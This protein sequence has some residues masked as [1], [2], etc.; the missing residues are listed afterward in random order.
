MTKLLIRLFIKNNTDTQ[1]PQIR[2]RYGMLAGVVGIILNLLLFAGKLIAGLV[3]GAISITADAFNNLSDAGSSIITLVGFK[4]ANAPADREHPFGHGRVEYLAGL[5]V[6]LLILLMGVE[7]A[8]SS[9]DKILRPEEISFSALTLV[10]LIVSVLVKLWM[11]VFN[12]RLGRDINSAPM[13]AAAMDS[14]SDAVATVAVIA[15]I[16]IFALFGVNIDGFIGMLVAIFICFTGLKTAKESFSPIVG[17]RPD[18]EFVQRIA[19]YVESY[20]GIIGIHDLIVHNYGVGV[21]II[22]LHAEV[23]CTME[24]MQAHELIDRLE[25]ELR[26]R[27]NCHVTIHMDP[28]AVNDPETMR[29]KERVEILIKAIDPELSMHDFRKTV[30]VHSENLIFDVVVP[31]QY[32]YS[33]EEVSERIRLAVSALDPK[34][35]TVIHIDKQLT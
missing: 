21:S 8:K 32:R 25:D 26:V 18:K 5:I 24:I 2:G 12:R 29:V 27:F 3:S 33:D 1:N 30:G 11:G 19:D 15:G 17:T 14:I 35:N 31:F 4:M 28:V 20:D 13:K 23:P 16:L 34:Y 9:L 10:I 22:S 6:S 7:L